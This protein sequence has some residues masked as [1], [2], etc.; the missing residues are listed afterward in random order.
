MRWVAK[1]LHPPAPALA[2]LLNL[3]TNCRPRVKKFVHP[4][5]RV[6]PTQHIRRSSVCLF[7]FSLSLCVHLEKQDT[8]TGEDFHRE[9]RV[10]PSAA[11]AAA[12][13][14]V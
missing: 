12:A 9:A 5:S 3:R 4:W 11:A 14:V 7:F 1:T 10:H 6:R 13:A 2:P 8:Q